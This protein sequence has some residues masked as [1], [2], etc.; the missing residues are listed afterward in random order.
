MNV[1]GS[2]TNRL[3]QAW[4]F[5]AGTERQRMLLEYFIKAWKPICLLLLAVTACSSSVRA[6]VVRFDT[7]LGV[8]NAR[9]YDTATPISVANFKAYVD[10]D[11]WDGSFIHRS[12]PGFVVQGGGFKLT[13]DIFH[14]TNVVTYPA[15]QN[16]FGISNL[17]GTI[18]YAKLG[19]DPNS[20]TSQWFFNLA[21]NSGNLDNQNGGFTVFGRV[22]GTGMT[23]V[24][25][26]AAL[27][28]IGAG[29]A[30]TEVPVTDIDQ[31]VAQQN[32][33]NTEAVVI[34]NVSVL[35]LPAGDYNFDGTVNQL[36][37]AVWRTDFGST[38]K[39]EADGNGDG[40]VDGR[41]FMIW[42][43]SFGQTSTLTAALSVVPEPSGLALG[44]LAL[45]GF[46]LRRQKSRSRFLSPRRP[47]APSE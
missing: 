21:N 1:E 46:V 6:T 4:P 17:R 3:R 7:S 36:D 20:A 10:S 23:V 28:R 26:I 37:L 45:V 11:R 13:P 42:Q 27:P 32:I 44:S 25:S 14:T 30:F 40:V 18:A 9:L 35:N 19:G 15:I 39:A 12:V 31:V 22:V 16:E 38:T 34:N 2:E 43:R 5:S 47:L 24:D 8:I 33:F 41:D 29:G